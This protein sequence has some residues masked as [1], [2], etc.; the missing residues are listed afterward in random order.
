MTVLVYR[1]WLQGWMSMWRWEMLS[2]SA[3]S[4]C[5]LLKVDTESS[6]WWRMTRK[7]KFWMLITLHLTASFGMAMHLVC[8][9]LVDMATDVCILYFVVQLTV[10][11]TVTLMLQ[12]CVCLS[13]VRNVLQ[14]NGASWSKSYYWQPIGSRIRESIGTKMNDLNLLYRSCQGH[15]NHCVT[16][17]I[18]YLGNR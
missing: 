7:V 17:A 12:C 1:V 2:E 5:T 18:E 16:F 11:S 13:S 9:P 10:L 4:P 3:T 14:L 15:V 6:R 8:Q